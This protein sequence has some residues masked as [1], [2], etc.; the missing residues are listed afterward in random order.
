VA[1]LVHAGWFGAASF[2]VWQP[3]LPQFNSLPAIIMDSISTGLSATLVALIVYRFVAITLRH[4]Q[5]QIPGELYFRIATIAA[6]LHVIPLT[7]FIL[8]TEL[9][10][11]VDTQ[12]VCVRGFAGFVIVA[13]ILLSSSNIGITTGLL[14]H[15]EVHRVRALHMHTVDSF[16]LVKKRLTRLRIGACF[17]II[18]CIGFSALIMAL[19]AWIQYCL[20][21]MKL[22]GCLVVLV[23]FT[24]DGGIL[25]NQH[26]TESTT[27]SLPT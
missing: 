23:Y 11:N 4:T 3:F 26:N 10:D 24:V 18:S 15:L 13:A 5:L 25:V 19:P 2:L 14:R 1:L 7:G 9:I 20:P 17:A 22:S 16:E 27:S 6:A 8:A 21:L 12:I